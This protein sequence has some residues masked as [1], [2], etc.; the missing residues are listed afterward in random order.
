MVWLTL[1]SSLAILSS[2][3]LIAALL[4]LVSIG[5]AFFAHII[6]WQV[7]LLLTFIV[8]IGGIHFYFKHNLIL[9]ISSEIILIVCA[10]GLF[11]HLFPGFNNTKYL[12]KVIVGPQSSPFSM[13]FNFDKALIPF[14]LL[15]CLPTLFSSRPTKT[16]TWRQWGL[17]VIA[18]PI[19]LLVATFAG[20][21]GFELHFPTWLPAFILC[22]LFFVSLAEEALFRGYLQQRLTLWLGS[23]YLALILSALLFGGLHFT[24]GPLLILFATLSGVIY[25]LAWMWSGKLWLAVSFH[26]GLNLVHLLFFTYPV[27]M[28]IG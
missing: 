3:R 2:H 4:L 9:K 22:N 16:A 8:I 20:G 1:A 11:I 5:L 19:L 27:K 13:Y 21:L 23:P 17:L 15:A 26:F 6:N 14:I 18:V 24:G 12:D 25:G 28:F 7:I 10:V